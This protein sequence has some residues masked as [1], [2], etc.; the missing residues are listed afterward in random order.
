[1]LAG[2]SVKFRFEAGD[3]MCPVIHSEKKP[4]SCHET[5]MCKM[6]RAYLSDRK[7]SLWLPRV[8]HYQWWTTAK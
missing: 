8:R 3:D 7:T 6:M 1:M 4:K 5:R 2:V